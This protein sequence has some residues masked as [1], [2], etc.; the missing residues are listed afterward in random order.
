M[1][2]GEITKKLWIYIKEHQLQDEKNKRLIVP[3]ALMAA[4]FGSNEPLDMMQLA[5]CISKNIVKD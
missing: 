4:F 5:K 3:D 2:R 1:S